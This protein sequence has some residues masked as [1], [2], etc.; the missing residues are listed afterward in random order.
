MKTALLC[1][2]LLFATTTECPADRSEAS[3]HLSFTVPDSIIIKD[4]EPGCITVETNV[5]VII[6]NSDGLSKA[7]DYGEICHACGKSVW[8]ERVAE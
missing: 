5:P 1:S 4:A 7:C 6:R 8:V 2:L 3:I